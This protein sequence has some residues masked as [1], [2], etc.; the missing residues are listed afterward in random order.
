MLDN[1]LVRPSRALVI[2]AGV[3]KDVVALGVGFE[4]LGVTGENGLSVLGRPPGF[5]GFLALIMLR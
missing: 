3:I 1:F 5:A 2:H 4:L